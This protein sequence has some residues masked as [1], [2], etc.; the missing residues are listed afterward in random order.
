MTRERSRAALAVQYEMRHAPLAEAGMLPPAAAR[1]T[2]PI[3]PYA[4]VAAITPGTLVDSAFAVLRDAILTGRLVPGQRLVETTLAKELG[5]S[6]GPV[7]EAVALLQKDGLVEMV[8]RRGRFVREI[9]VQVVEESYKLL[10]VLEV[11]AVELVIDALDEPKMRALEFAATRAEKCS[12]GG[13]AA[14]AAAADLHLHQVLFDLSGQQLLMK[15]WRDSMAGELH[16]LAHLIPPMEL[17]PRT[18][19]GYYALLLAAIRL[20]DL[21]RAQTL[22]ADHVEQ[23][24]RATLQA[25]TK[26]VERQEPQATTARKLTA[27]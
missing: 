26:P 16:L 6:R 14:K 21:K 18:T 24:L 9:N 2:P 11:Y 13:P 1:T 3:D 8:P 17:R 22:V 25:I 12:E 4:S 7:R 19:P 23:A 5:I 27:G 15:I 10:T 20:R